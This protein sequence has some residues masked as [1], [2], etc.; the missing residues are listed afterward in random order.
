MGNG[1]LST[2]PGSPEFGGPL[3]NDL[4]SGDTSYPVF[5]QRLTEKFL[6]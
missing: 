4:K 1:G 6:L 3:S 2:Q 5:D